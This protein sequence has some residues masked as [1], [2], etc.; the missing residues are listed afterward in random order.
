MHNAVAWADFWSHALGNLGYETN[1]VISNVEPLQR[2]W[3]HEHD[4]TWDQADWLAQVTTAQIKNFKPDVLFVNDYVTYTAAYLRRLRS[5]CPSIR[6]ILGWCGAP[7]SDP[8]VFSEYDVVLSSVPELVQD[9]RAQGHVCFQIDHAFDPRILERLDLKASPTTDFAFVGSITKKN[10]FHREREEQLLELIRK[11]DL[12]IWAAVG[13]P[14]LS[15]RSSIRLK[16]IAYDVVHAGQDIRLLAPL[17]R[18]A[19]FARKV[20]HW[21]ARPA[22]PQAVDPGIERRAHAPLFGLP[23]FQQL[24]QSK[25][26]LNTHIGISLSHASNMRL[27][28]ATGVG[29]CLLTD[30]KGNLSELFE[31]DREILA[32]RSI[33]EAIEKLRYILDH[34][35]ERRAIADAGQTRT[36]RDHTFDRRAEQL[37]ELL[38]Q[39]MRLTAAS[40]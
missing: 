15:E 17:M 18:A 40:A 12:Q 39:E 14:S 21:E 25:V 29:S 7:Y 16:Q 27:Y 33:D 34:E 11:T 5:E 35:S 4:L 20:T 23:M 38:Q 8:S 3:A 30:W 24:R 6:I 26:L 28:E 13:H 10:N 37:D 31:P 2:A 9:F 36:L 22:L 32:Y 19:P 1:E